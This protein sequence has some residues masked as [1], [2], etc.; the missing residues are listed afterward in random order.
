MRQ[1]R[2]GHC[3]NKYFQL[4]W[5][6]NHFRRIKMK[7]RRANSSIMLKCH[8]NWVQISLIW[9]WIRLV[10]FRLEV[11]LWLCSLKLP[12]GMIHFRG[13]LWVYL[14]SK[15]LLRIRSILWPNADLQLCLWKITKC[16]ILIQK[17]KSFT[18]TSMMFQGPFISWR[19]QEIPTRFS[20]YY[21]QTLRPQTF[22]YVRSSQK[23][24]PKNWWPIV[25][26]PSK[27]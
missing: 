26:T 16:L 17:G 10:S 7:L 13:K 25:P 22:S 23:R 14:V 6:M 3:L 21:S 18:G 24:K 19:S 8:K 15:H 4:V 5:M 9:R 20:S 12:K 11:D 27:S 1:I 2:L